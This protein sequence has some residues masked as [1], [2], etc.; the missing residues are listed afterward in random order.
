M[1]DVFPPFRA[2]ISTTVG[3]VRYIHT[4]CEL[5]C[6]YLFVHMPTNAYPFKSW[7]TSTHSQLNVKRHRTVLNTSSESRMNRVDRI[8]LFHVTDL[9]V[10]IICWNSQSGFSLIACDINLEVMS[11]HHSNLQD[12]ANSC[13]CKSMFLSWLHSNSIDLTDWK[14]YKFSA[15]LT[16]FMNLC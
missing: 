4:E 10:F 5:T 2:V 8:G 1:H 12:Q 15:F 7:F 14:S 3:C 13:V 9:P 16:H 6:W 11:S